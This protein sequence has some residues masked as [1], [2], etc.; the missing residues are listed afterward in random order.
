MDVFQVWDFY[1]AKHEEQCEDNGKIEENLTKAN[2]MLNNDV[3]FLE[4][5]EQQGN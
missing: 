2:E 3:H 4:Q 1:K 5:I